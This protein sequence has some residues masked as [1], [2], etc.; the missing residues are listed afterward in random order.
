MH[1]PCNDKVALKMLH[2]LERSLLKKPTERAMEYNDQ[3]HD[4][5]QRGADVLLTEKVRKRWD[6]DYH[7]LPIVRVKGKKRLRVC[8]H[9]SPKQCCCESMNYH[10]CKGPDCFMYHLFSVLLAFHNGRVGCT[11]DVKKFQ[12]QV[13]LLEEGIHMQRFLWRYMETD[14][15]PQ[16]YVVAVNNFTSKTRQP[17]CDM[18][19]A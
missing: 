13:H 8:F 16:H 19:F 14:K 17:H 5:D 7:Y 18:S 15:E 3:I 12:N 1:F 6:G 9:V 2:V 11:G 4:M 10:L